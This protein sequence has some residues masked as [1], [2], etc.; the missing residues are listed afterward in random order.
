MS[1]MAM[2]SP[3]HR[4]FTALLLLAAAASVRADRPEGITDGEI[5]LLPPYC[6]DTQ[7]FSYG[8]SANNMSPRAPRWIALMGETF[9]AMHHYCW[10]LAN[11]R[12]AQMAGVPKERRAYL[13]Q[14]AIDDYRFVVRNAPATFVLLPEIYTRIGEAHVF[15]RQYTQAGSAFEKARSLK[16]DYW[17]PYVAWIDVLVQLK[18]TTQARKLLSEGL[19]IMPTEPALLAKAAALGVK[20][21]PA[22]AA[23][24]AAPASAPNSPSAEPA[25]APSSPAAGQAVQP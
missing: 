16:P 17:P 21:P 6:V 18:L 10:G 11:F 7:G 14:T 8:A 22:P 24:A 2:T 12:R 15:L 20:V 25:P 3:L 4:L 1:N 9:W 5:A 23:S 13:V 19:A